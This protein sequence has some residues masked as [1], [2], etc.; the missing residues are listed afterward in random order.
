MYGANQLNQAKS[1]LQAAT[2]MQDI[3]AQGLIS[4]GKPKM[5]PAMEAFSM[6]DSRLERLRAQV[7][8]LHDRLGPVL[9]SASPQPGAEAATAP[10]GAPLL[11]AVSQATERVAQMERMVSEMTDRLI[12]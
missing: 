7:F 2:A 12:I 10:A 11:E 5:T 9:F 1:K 4:G 6:L 8:R 3:A